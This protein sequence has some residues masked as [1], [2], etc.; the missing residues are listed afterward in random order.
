MTLKLTPADLAELTVAKQQL[1]STDIAVRL[2]D[3][4]GAPIER[5]LDMLP[6]KASELLND[7]VRKAIEKALDLA[8]KSIDQQSAT[9]PFAGKQ[10]HRWLAAGSGAVG[11]AFGFAGFALE[12]PVSTGLILRSIAEIARSQ[13]E[14][15]ET[16]ETRLAC[17]EVFAYGSP[18]S[19]ARDDAAETG[20]FAMRQVLAA[21]V[22][23]AASHIAK[24]GLSG[25][26]GPALAR[27]VSA[28]AARFSVTAGK[29]LAAQLIPIAGA[30][31]GAA[32][33][34]VFIDHF[35]KIAAGH[36]TVRRLERQYG[37][38]AVRKAYE[39]LG[40]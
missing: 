1:E 3:A 23:Q 30:L 17:V 14:D 5:G 12:L 19:S 4:V 40:A 7:T 28:I 32:I 15:L 36:F 2:A 35:Q 27:F 9:K 8:I 16:A 25:S 24:H 34:T 26:G 11:G 29:K 37:A 39:Y 6:D 13:G 22:S 38:D 31:G 18:A 33:N 10:L 20:Y 21:S